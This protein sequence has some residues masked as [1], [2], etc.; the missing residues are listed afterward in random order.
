[1]NNYKLDPKPVLEQGDIVVG[2][3]SDR[4]KDKI[5]LGKL[6]ES[7][8]IRNIWL[9]VTGEQVVAICGKRGSGK[10]YTL[11]VLIEGLAASSKNSKIA[12]H[13]T[14]RAGLVFDIMDIFW[15]SQIELSDTE[16]KEIKKQYQLMKKKGFQAENLNITVWVPSG[17]EN[18]EIDPPGIQCLR[19]SAKDL[20]I[21]DWAALFNVDIFTEPRG[22]LI[23]DIV[24]HVSQQGYYIENGDRVEPNPNFNFSDL[25]HCLE[26][27]GEILQNYNEN[28]VRSIRQRMISYSSLGVFQGTPT[29]LTE[30]IKAT[31]V[32]TLMLGR[33]PDA[34]KKVI[35]SVISRKILR[36]RRDASFAQKRLDLQS[37]ISSDEKKRLQNVIQSKI[38]RTWILM[39]EA[40]VLAGNSEGSVAKDALIKYAKE[41]RNYGLSL[42]VATQ[43][44][45]ALDSRLM[46]QVE[47]MITHQLTAPKDADLAC[48][49]IRS[50][51]ADR[52]MVNGVESTE[53]QL[54][55][56]LEQGVAVFSCGN[57]PKI[58]RFC[59][60]NIRPRISA[61]GGYEA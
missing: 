3:P 33:V 41:G 58:T 32:S 23:V 54:L 55:R 37:D 40:H 38:P 25:I 51:L 24:N 57:A 2:D 45:S 53:N 39:D 61:H 46:S 22:M 34:L 13:E 11:G 47:T 18:T 5:L 42:A 35:V 30:L 26:N 31:S 43:Q 49:N 50:P 20:E 17:Y 15:T 8:A 44:P 56:Q 21:D 29:P 19:F 10:S 4:R 59:V 48:N 12:K 36:E 1:M 7:G 16:S 9:D 60:V 27:D 6:A 14:L 52:I 28:T